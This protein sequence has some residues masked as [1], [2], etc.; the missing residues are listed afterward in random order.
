MSQVHKHNINFQSLFVIASLKSVIYSESKF[1]KLLPLIQALLSH[2]GLQ[3][4]QVN[5]ENMN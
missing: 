5:P 3:E 2:L 4:G 1:K